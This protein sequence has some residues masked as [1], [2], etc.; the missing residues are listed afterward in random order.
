MPSMTSL[1][2]R[3]TDTANRK[4]NT[5]SFKYS[6]IIAKQ[7]CRYFEF[8]FYPHELILALTIIKKFELLLEIN[9]KKFQYYFNTLFLDRNLTV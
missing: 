9:I 3:K 1:I 7:Q 2:G 4:N 5:I 8:I 6:A